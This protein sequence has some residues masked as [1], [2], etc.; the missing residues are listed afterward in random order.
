MTPLRNY[1]DERPVLGAA[2]R[3]LSLFPTA[4]SQEESELIDLP[5]RGARGITPGAGKKMNWRRGLDPSTTQASHPYLR[6]VDRLSGIHGCRL[7]FVVS[8]LISIKES[9]PASIH[10]PMTMFRLRR[11]GLPG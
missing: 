1:R 2:P 9:A 8:P 10:N 4:L 3:A 7:S 6:A 5:S 11:F